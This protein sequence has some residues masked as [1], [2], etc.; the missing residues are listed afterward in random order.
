[1]DILF[2]LYG[3][4]GTIFKDIVLSFKG[5]VD[6]VNCNSKSK[7]FITLKY[8]KETK[9]EINRFFETAVSILDNKENIDP[10]KP[11]MSVILNGCSTKSD[12]LL[13]KAQFFEFLEKLKITEDENSYYENSGNNEYNLISKELTEKF[14]DEFNKDETYISLIF[15]YINYINILREGDNSKSIETTNF[16]FLTSNYTL[17]KM[18][19]E[20]KEMHN[21]ICPKTI[22]LD[23]LITLLWFNLKKGFGDLQNNPSLNVVNKAKIIISSKLNSSVSQEYFHFM[24]LMKE[25]QLDEKGAALYLVELHK[26]AKLPEQITSDYLKENGEL[27]I[28]RQDIE[29]RINEAS[30]MESRNKTL[31]S[32]KEEDKKTIQILLSENNKL[33]KELQQRREEERKKAESVRKIKRIVRV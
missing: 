16:I 33:E 15:N 10:S 28:S 20:L 13:K 12:I 1:M 24:E 31:L 18:D 22:N 27:I 5:L 3:Y 14:V 8:F 9:R 25:N 7:N 4:N 29:A 11:A 19:C 6:E 30:I 23:N 2:S 17:I 26:Y 32:E 21:E